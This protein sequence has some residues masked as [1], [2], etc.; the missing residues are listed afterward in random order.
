M[1]KAIQEIRRLSM[2]KEKA[3]GTGT[4]TRHIQ[5]FAITPSPSTLT[6]EIWSDTQALR[7]RISESRAQGLSF[8]RISAVIGLHWRPISGSQVQS[9]IMSQEEV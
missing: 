2:S 4:L 9:T 1:Q 7:H 5:G 6:R 8:R 3:R